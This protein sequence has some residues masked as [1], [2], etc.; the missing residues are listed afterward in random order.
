MMKMIGSPTQ[1]E[2]KMKV[3]NNPLHMMSD[4]EFQRTVLDG[5]IAPKDANYTLSVSIAKI[6]QQYDLTS[7]IAELEKG[8]NSTS[9]SKQ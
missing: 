5:E 4:V 9:H 6:S 3:K 8:S 1:K 2:M 7:V